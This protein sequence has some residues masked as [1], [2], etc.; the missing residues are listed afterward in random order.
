MDHI[1][2]LAREVDFEAI[3]D[4]GEP[5]T[6]PD[7]PPVFESIY[8]PDCFVDLWEDEIATLKNV[9]FKRV[10]EIYGPDK[11]AVFND[12]EPNDIG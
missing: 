6:D 5:W 1:E 11:L 10:S 2:E 4:R 8:T 12:I 3:I 7:F 9:E